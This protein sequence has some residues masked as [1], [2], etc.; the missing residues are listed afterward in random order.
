M[1]ISCNAHIVEGRG[2]GDAIVIAN[3]ELTHV[4][5]TSFILCYS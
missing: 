3:V 1:W 4:Q 2:G 5:K